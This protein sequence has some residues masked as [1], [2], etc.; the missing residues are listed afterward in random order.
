MLCQI[1][2]LS[3]LVATVGATEIEFEHLEFEIP[4]EWSQQVL[5]NYRNLSETYL[6]MT[7]GRR[8]RTTEAEFQEIWH[9]LRDLL[10]E[11]QPMIHDALRKQY[12]E[13]EAELKTDQIERLEV[14]QVSPPR[15]LGL[16]SDNY[17]KE[18]SLPVYCSIHYRSPT[19][20]SY[21]GKTSV[22]QFYCLPV[23]KGPVS[24]DQLRLIFEPHFYTPWFLKGWS[25]VGLVALVWTLIVLGL[26]TFC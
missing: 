17:S 16:K 14:N 18:Y 11:N 12:L 5:A 26:K 4:K 24:W 10:W 19:S 25:A 9:K 22:Y 8:P 7:Q 15:L 6:A 1:L 21:D 2:V 13:L 20:L 3:L 23:K